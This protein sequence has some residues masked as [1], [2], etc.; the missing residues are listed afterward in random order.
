MARSE[1]RAPRPDRKHREVHSTGEPSHVVE[2]ACVAREPD[3]Q[4]AFDDE[5]DRMRAGPTG[6]HPVPRRYGG[7]GQRTDGD[8][9]ADDEL[10]HV[11]PRSSACGGAETARD[12]ECRSSWDRAERRRIEMVRVGVRDED[13]VDPAQFRRGGERPVTLQRS[14]PR[15]EERVGQDA[16]RWEVQHHGCVADEAQVEPSGRHGDRVRDVEASRRRAGRPAD[17]G[18]DGVEPDDAAASRFLPARLR[19]S[20]R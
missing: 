16:C 6:C 4:S 5:P 12:D 18:P 1:V 13:D 17:R 3:A 11:S 19:R 15:T 7:D 2:R 9:L 10:D 20:S 8:L 14:K